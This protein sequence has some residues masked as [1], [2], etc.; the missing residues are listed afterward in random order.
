M[1]KIFGTDGIRGKVN[2][3]DMTPETALRTGRAVACYLLNQNGKDSVIMGKDTRISGD[4]IEAA[5]AAGITSMG[6]NAV[7]TGVISTPGIAFLTRHMGAGAG[8]MISASHNPFYDNGIKLFKENGFKLTDEEEERIEKLILENNIYLSKGIRKTG[9]ILKRE[10]IR[11]HYIDFIEKA[12]DKKSIKN[13]KIV[14]DCA[15]GSLSYIAPKIFKELGTDITAIFCEPDGININ[16]KCG[17]QYPEILAERVK[18]ENADI[19]FAFD[20]DGDRVIAVDEKGNILTGDQLIV[21]FAKNYKDNNMLGSSNTV[22]TT[23]MSNTGLKLA[24]SDMGIRH[25]S[26]DVGD[27][28][29]FFK[30][31]QEKS[32]L[33]GEDSGHIIFL[34]HLNT[35]DGLL[36]AL[37]LLKALAD[38]KKPLSELGGLMKIFPQSLINVNVSKKQNINEVSP[39]MEAVKEAEA[40]LKDKGRVLVRYSGTQ[41][42][43]RVM[44]EGESEKETEKLCRYIAEVVK[45]NLNHGLNGYS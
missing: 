15:N 42:I 25:V 13:L 41:P 23:I 45:A 5:V 31:L 4:M 35:G 17:S 30:M 26:S 3:S 16:D 9:R 24:L 14:I 10:D 40:V 20:G 22:I 2:D 29:V 1:R 12:A 8:I 39:I 36:V 33:G 18:K 7:L 21:I 34:N 19:G 6:V 38:A 43:C 37:M 44:V 27:R 11:E 28:Y 32:V